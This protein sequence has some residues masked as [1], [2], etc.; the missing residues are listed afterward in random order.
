M[1]AGKEFTQEEA[2]HELA[3]NLGVMIGETIKDHQPLTQQEQCTIIVT[4]LVIVINNLLAQ[5]I[6][7]AKAITIETFK[8]EI[9]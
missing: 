6:P 8:R 7:E 5:L 1:T 9:K 3:N 2:T 4:A